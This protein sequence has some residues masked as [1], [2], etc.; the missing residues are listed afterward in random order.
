[1]NFERTHSFRRCAIVRATA[2]AHVHIT[3]NFRHYAPTLHVCS[4][5]LSLFTQSATLN[6]SHMGFFGKEKPQAPTPSEQET[7][8][9]KK[10]CC[11]CPETKVCTA[12]SMCYY[13]CIVILYDTHA[14]YIIHNSYDEDGH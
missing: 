14:T 4:V 6:A 2:P 5:I 10:I 9:K 12:P 13:G 8:P 7:T 1:M 11:A 3:Y